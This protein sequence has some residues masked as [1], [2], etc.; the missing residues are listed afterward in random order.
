M[1]GAFEFSFTKDDLSRGL[2][3]PAGWYKAKI[4]KV[5]TKEANT[6][7]ST[8]ILVH[9]KFTVV[10]NDGSTRDKTLF[11]IFNEKAKGFAVPLFLA[12]NGGVPLKEGQSYSFNSL[13]G[14]E[15]EIYI[16]ETTYEGKLRNEVADYRPLSS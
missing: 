12:A 11:R 8:N 15:M 10:N 14:L 4:V 5:E 16:K 1:S 7:K 3:A 6:D 2:P 9:F 13:E